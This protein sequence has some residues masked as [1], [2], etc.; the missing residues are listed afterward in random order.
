MGTECTSRA[1]TGVT[2]PIAKASHR[3]RVVAAYVK[4]AAIRSTR[5]YSR[6]AHPTVIGRSA[7]AD[8]QVGRSGQRVC[9]VTGEQLG[10]LGADCPGTRV[11]GVPVGGGHGAVD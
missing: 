7:Y 3:T 4:M 9:R 2:A 1:R 11:L 8:T 5:R 10:H 6:T